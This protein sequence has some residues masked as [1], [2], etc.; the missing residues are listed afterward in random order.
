MTSLKSRQAQAVRRARLEIDPMD[1]RNLMTLTA[2]A[3]AVGALSSAAKA[4]GATRAPAVVAGDGTRIGWRQWGAGRPVVFLHSWGMRSDMWDYQVAALADRGARCIAYDQRGHGR[5]DAPADGYDFDTLADDLAAVLETLD[6]RD[7]ALV[8][9]SMGAGEIARYLSRHGAGR[10]ARVAFVAPAIPSM[11]RSADN[12]AG[13]PEAGFE[14]VRDLWRTDF[15]RW[16]ADNTPAFFTPRTSAQMSRWLIDMLLATPLPILIEC[17]RRLTRTD[18]RPDLR[19]M[20]VP[21]LIIHG[22]A[23]ASAPID[24]TGRVAAGLIPQ[25]RLKVYPGAP[26]GLF[27]THM[28]QL[29]Q[30]LAD[31][32]APRRS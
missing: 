29:N 3:A 20:A 22:D 16:V 14:A 19:A 15:P 27:V 32:I 5:S 11:L 26:H 25:A 21:T 12:P 6:L 8:G 18:F 17:N 7:V 13:V 30:D 23:D 31:F 10:I 9:H 24:V 2:G 28:A 1:R 4:G